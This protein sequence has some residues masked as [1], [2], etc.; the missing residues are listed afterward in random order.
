MTGSIIVRFEKKCFEKTSLM[1][2]KQVILNLSQDLFPYSCKH[3]AP[4]SRPKDRDLL[5]LIHNGVTQELCGHGHIV[6]SEIQ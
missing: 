5:K 6:I 4:I 2:S 3:D 1:H